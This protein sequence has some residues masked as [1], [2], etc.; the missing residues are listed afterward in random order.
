MA[1][2]YYVVA[3]SQTLHDAIRRAA[4]YS[5]LVNEGVLQRFTAGRQLTITLD[6][7]G[8][9][10]RAE[11][12]QVEC[13]MTII[14]RLLRQL[15]G[16]R[17]VPQRVRF[18][19]PRETVPAELASYFGRTPEFSAPADDISFATTVGTT[20]VVSA[21]PHLNALLVRYCEEAIA[22]RR[23]GRELFRT[24]VENAIVRLLPHAE[25]SVRGIAAVLGIGQRTL[26]RRLS[27]EGITF[28]ALLDELRLD[29]AH[30]YLAE[31]STS[32][33][34]IAWL[35]GYGE[36]SAFSKAFKRW[37][38]MSPREAR[39]RGKPRRTRRR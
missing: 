29:L 13:F 1:L 4:R 37:T 39:L 10:R 19:H 38:G 3:S 22:Y 24:R 27:G 18:I 26:A 33:S 30:R 31:P 7:V 5:S 35:L 36:V 8:V 17:I 6:H 23:P 21:D 28:S 15:G 2:L 14:L 32:I 9:S 25:V 34:Q 16:V 11:C 20:H 12:H